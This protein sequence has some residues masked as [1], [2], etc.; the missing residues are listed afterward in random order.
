MGM[1]IAM[2]TAIAITPR[3]AVTGSRR[4][5]SERTDWRVHNDS[6]KSPRPT[7]ASQ[8]K[9]CTWIGRFNPSFAR[10][11]SRSLPYAFSSSISW[12]TSPG[13]RRGSVKTMSEA[14]EQRGDRDQQAA[15]DIVAHEHA[16][17]R[18]ATRRLNPMRRLHAGDAGCL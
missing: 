15:E 12:T 14:I 9:Y 13:M 6:P 8:S 5:S 4:T 11:S 16:G 18:R 1:A 17:G 7:V 3:V 2:A 10:R